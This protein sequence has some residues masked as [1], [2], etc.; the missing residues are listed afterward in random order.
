VTAG[1]Q[2]DNCRKFS[3]GH[4]P[5]WLYLIQQPDESDE[6]PIIAALFGTPSEPL[7]FC[8]VK[9][10]AEY[11]Y[12]KAITGDSGVALLMGRRTTAAQR[13]YMRRYRADPV[14]AAVHAW[15]SRTR[16]AALKE[17]ARRHPGEYAAVL[18]GIREEDPKPA[19]GEDAG[20]A[21]A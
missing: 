3:P 4:T 5:G 20:D 17:L 14:A 2:C 18:W 19:A 11:T 16:H 7:T 1:N 21:A 12:A 9:C 15:E 6:P 10:V 8:T 13:A